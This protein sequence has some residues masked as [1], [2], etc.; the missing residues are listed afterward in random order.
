MASKCR[1][2]HPATLPQI[3]SNLTKTLFI[4]EV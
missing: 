4:L 3:P 2:V 1:E